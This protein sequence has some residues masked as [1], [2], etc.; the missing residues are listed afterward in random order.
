MKT[1][2]AQHPETLLGSSQVSHEKGGHLTSSSSLVFFLTLCW[3][4]QIVDEASWFFGMMRAGPEV[5]HT[6][7][8]GLRSLCSVVHRDSRPVAACERRWPGRRAGGPAPLRSWSAAGT[9]SRKDVNGRELA[10]REGD[11]ATGSGHGSRAEASR[12]AARARTWSPAEHDL[13][14]P[15]HRHTHARTEVLHTALPSGGAGRRSGTVDG[16]ELPRSM[17]PRVGRQFETHGAG[18]RFYFGAVRNRVD[19]VGPW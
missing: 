6:V 15:H 17:R 19:I 4:L 10:K 11:I 2:L 8:T 12:T 3:I 1:H 16:H 13:R 14:R 18:R 5:I 9:A 7:F